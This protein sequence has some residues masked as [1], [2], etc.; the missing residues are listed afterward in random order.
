MLFKKGFENKEICFFYFNYGTLSPNLLHRINRLYHDQEHNP[1]TFI[2]LTRILMYND[3][4]NWEERCLNK[5]NF[6][7]SNA[8]EYRISQLINHKFGQEVL[9]VELKTKPSSP[10]ISTSQLI[11]TKLIIEKLGLNCKNEVSFHDYLIDVYIPSLETVVEMDGPDHFYPLQSQFKNIS[12]F[13]YHYLNTFYKK[14]L[15]SIPYFEF[16]RQ[17]NDYLL[18]QLLYKLIYSEY[19][20]FDSKLFKTNFDLLGPIWEFKKIKVNSNA[21]LL[22]KI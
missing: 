17:D 12:K 19:D 8:F 1:K 20:L 22:N 6:F 7:K 13:R 15:V 9:N 3:I 11:E 18:G 21:N 14:R 10:F 5:F 4:K 16:T 2:I